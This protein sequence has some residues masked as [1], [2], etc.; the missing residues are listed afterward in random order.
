[1]V[2]FRRPGYKCSHY[3]DML[4]LQGGLTALHYACSK[5]HVE[6]VKLL[7]SNN[8]DIAATDNV[9]ECLLFKVTGYPLN[10]LKGANF[11]V[12]KTTFLMFCVNWTCYHLQNT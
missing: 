5:G 8:A 1:M 9:S 12:H 6:V 4:L 11:T 3:I 10:N 7:I 2:D